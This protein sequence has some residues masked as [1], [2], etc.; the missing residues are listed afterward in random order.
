MPPEMRKTF[1]LL[2]T[3][4]ALVRS[5]LAV[6]LLVADE[7][8]LSLEGLPTFPTAVLSVVGVDVSSML[9]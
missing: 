9:L 8:I 7:G 2:A 5:R 6:N 1:V 4:L 3:T